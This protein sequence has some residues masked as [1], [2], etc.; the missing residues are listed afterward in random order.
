MARFIAQNHL[1]DPADL[2]GFNIGGYAFRSDMSDATRLV[3]LRPAQDA[4]AA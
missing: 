1:T 2:R 3:F 4:A